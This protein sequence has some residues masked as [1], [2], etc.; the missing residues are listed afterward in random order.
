MA[1][2]VPNIYLEITPNMYDRTVESVRIACGETPEFP[3]GIGLQ[4]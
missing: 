3:V 4:L 2:C 1:K